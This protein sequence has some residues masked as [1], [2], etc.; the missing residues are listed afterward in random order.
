MRSAL[1]F[2]HTE[3]RSKEL[4]RSALLT[5]DHLEYIVPFVGYN[6]NY[7][8]QDS[9]RAMEIIGRPRVASTDDQAKVHALV[10]E[11]LH[12]GVPETFRYSP[13]DGRQT[14][15]Y[16]MWPQKLM[17]KT[18][19]L[20]RTH[21]LTD[22]PLSN[23]DYPTSQAAGLTLMAII[24][25]VLAGDTRSRITDQGLAYATIANVSKVDEQPEDYEEV[26]PLTLKVASLDKV[27]M[28]RLIE[29]RERE[30]KSAA[31]MDYRTLRHNYLAAIEKHAERISKTSPGSADRTELDRNFVSDIEKDFYDLKT[32]LGIAKR[33]ALFTK[34]MFTLVLAA[35]AAAVAAA[36]GAPVLVPS[37]I[38][39]SGGVVMLGGLLGTA[40]K[41]GKARRD[42][43]RKHSMAYLYELT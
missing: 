37:A 40:N 36:A 19:D 16:E 11:L 34:E 15:E 1:Y 41:F 35:G 12:K 43:M 13:A 39:G 26:V 9:A 22:A 25:D 17:G 4:I 29:F 23:M 27:P 33:D 38:A 6:T 28:S 3:V 7:D 20:L 5:W 18:W 2:P 14:P 21:G 42:V 8:D 24:A 31:G 30:E 32:E 10:D